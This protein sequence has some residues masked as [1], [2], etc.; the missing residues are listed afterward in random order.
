MEDVRE[1]LRAVARELLA[2]GRKEEHA[3]E[4]TVPAWSSLADAG[5]LGLEVDDDLGGSGATFAETAVVVEELGRA[6]AATPY[7]GTAAL[8]VGMLNRIEPSGVRNDLLRGV[9]TGTARVAVVAGEDGASPVFSLDGEMRLTGRAVFVPDATQAEHLLV[10]ARNPAG[11][12]VVVR[13]G[14]GAAGIDVTPCPVLDVTRRLADVATAELGGVGVMPEAVLRFRGDPFTA[15][16]A[17]RTRAAVS[18]A[19][20]ALGLCEAMLA[21]TVA[22][23]CVRT[24]FDRPIGSFQAVKH[25][26]AD[27]LVT[28]RVGRMLL[29]EAVAAIVD[30]HEDAPLAAARAKAYLTD[31][32]VEVAGTALQLHGGIGYTW[33]SGIHLYLK[34][35]MLDRSL[36]GAPAIHRRRLAQ[37]WV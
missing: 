25:S 33:E 3:R 21:S 10:V 22:Y 5:W 23:A 6:V 17:L 9:A 15:V 35:A 37:R 29:D 4:P 12:P 13:L 19:A 8:G 36:F 7:L 24:Q 11:T 34:R 28:A 14:P 30:G 31:A 20:D 26:C 18:V 32:A 27:L 16:R 1:E 2:A